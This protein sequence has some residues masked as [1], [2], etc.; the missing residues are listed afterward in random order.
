MLRIKTTAND[1][2]VAKAQS[3]EPGTDNTGYQP[4]GP[5]TCGSRGKPP[6]DGV[7]AGHK[8][9]GDDMQ[10]QAQAI[11]ASFGA[12]ET[13]MGTKSIDDIADL[14]GPLADEE[15]PADQ[16]EALSRTAAP[17]V[18]LRSSMLKHG[19]VTVDYFSAS[20]HPSL[21]HKLNDIVS[22]TH[23]RALSVA[24]KKGKY[25]FSIRETGALSI[26]RI[27]Q[28]AKP[29]PH[30]ILEKSI[31]ESSLAKAYGQQAMQAKL[32]LLK[33]KALDGF[34]GHWQNGKLIG[35]RADNYHVSETRIGDLDKPRHAADV[36][37][38]NNIEVKDIFR[39]DNKGNRLKIG[40]YI[41]INL[42]DAQSGFTEIDKL[43]AIPHWQGVL[44]TGDYDI[45][46]AYSFKGGSKGQIAEGS[47]EK[48]RFLNDLNAAT[49][50]YSDDR[51]RRGK[52][53][54]GRDGLIHNAGAY[55][56]FQHGDQAT[57]RMNQLLEAK[58]EAEQAN[59]GNRYR[60]GQNKAR[61]VEAVATESDEPLAWCVQGEWYVT[62]NKEE[63]QTFRRLKNL[64]APSTWMTSG[65]RQ[66][67]ESF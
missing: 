28:G 6:A 2:I 64:T 29:K 40:S 22:A 65:P 59:P 15:K 35:V 55:A 47:L 30:S 41:P 60:L 48:A 9:G 39:Q 67:I 61:L 37:A 8:V 1:S 12:V 24:S 11:A 32:E 17:V 27:Q 13:P 34:A 33:A 42:D 4:A 56:M 36:L 50:R 54:V 19:K 16:G 23:Q 26:N 43:K 18:S 66:R 38:E 45:H 14:F 3:R 20:R 25:S 63:H 53:K 51:F 46:E 31:K 7:A 62:A 44:Y 52:A 58:K 10:S 5:E 57:Y 21:Q 49:V